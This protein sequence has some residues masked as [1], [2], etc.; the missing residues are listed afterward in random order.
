MQRRTL[1]LHTASGTR[2]QWVLVCASCWLVLNATMS[3]L[4]PQGSLCGHHPWYS[5]HLPGRE[6]TPD[7][8][9]HEDFEILSV[10]VTK[11][12]VAASTV[13]T[14]FAWYR[15]LLPWRATGRYR[16]PAGGDRR[17]GVPNYFGE[18]RFATMAATSKP[19]PDC[20]S[21]LATGGQWHDSLRR[22]L[23]VLTWCW[24]SV[25][26]AKWSTSMEFETQPCTA[27]GSWRSAAGGELAE[28]EQAVLFGWQSCVMPLNMPA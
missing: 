19:E 2:I 23:L 18:Q 22:P 24:P 28:L 6:L 14:N 12:C 10:T 5:L 17:N 27:L 1:L 8:L 4:W 15:S 9:Q 20:G 13:A 21:L 7:Q 11:N 16:G 26:N 3:V 25:F